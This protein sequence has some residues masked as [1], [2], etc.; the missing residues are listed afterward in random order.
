VRK[1]PHLFRPKLTT[2]SLPAYQLG[3]K[4]AELLHRK[5]QGELADIDGLRVRGQLFIRQ[6]CGAPLALQTMDDSYPNI[7]ERHL[8][9]ALANWTFAGE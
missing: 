1:S 5:L 2:V 6:S 3:Y 8:L 4:A 9:I 7:N